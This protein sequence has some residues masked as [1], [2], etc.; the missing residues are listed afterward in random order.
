MTVDNR[1]GM[2]GRQICE[3]AT[4]Q[5][6]LRLRRCWLSPRCLTGGS[7]RALREQGRT[8]CLPQLDRARLLGGRLVAP[9]RRAQRR[10]EGAG[11]RRRGRAARPSQPRYRPPRGRA[12]T[13]AACSPRRASASARTPRHAIAAFRSSPASASLSWLSASA[14]AARPCAQERAAEQRRGL[15]RVDAEALRAQPLVGGAQAALGGGGVALEQLDEPGEDVGLEEPLRDAELLDHAPRRRDHAP[16]RLGAPAQRLEHRLAA[17]RDR[18]DRRRALRDAQHAHDVETA[19]ARARHRAR[20]PQRGQRRAGEH[21]VGAPPVAARA[22]RRRARGR[23][24]PRTRRS[25]R[26]ARARARAPSAPSPRRRRRPPRRAS[27]AAAAT[28]SAVARSACGSVSTASWPAKQVCQARRRSELAGEA[29]ELV[30]RPR[31]GADVAGREQRLAPVERQLGARGIRGI[32]PIERAAEQ[33]RRERQVVARR[34]R[35]GPRPRGSAPRA[36]RG[37][38]R[39]SSSG[40]S[41]RRCWCACSRCQ[42]IV[43]SCSTASPARASSQSAKRPCSSARVPFSSAPV[44]GVADQHVVEAQRPARRGTSRCRARSARC[45]AA[46]RAARRGRVRRPAAAG[47]RPRRART[48]GRRPRRARARCAPRGASR[49]MR[50]ASSAW[51]VGGISSAASSTPAVQRSPSRLSTPSWTSMRT[52][53]PTK[54]GLPSLVASTRPAIA[55]GSSSAPITFAASRVAAPASRPRERHHV[56]DETAGR[57]RATSARR[58]ARGAPPRGRAAARR[59]STA[60]GARSGRAAAAPPTAGRRSRARPAAAAASAARKAPDDEEGLLR[61]RRRPGEERGDARRRSGRARPRRRAPAPRSPRACASPSAPS[62]RRRCARSASASGAK[63]APPAASQRAVEHGRARRPSRRASSAS[64]RDLPRPGE[65][66]ITARR[67][68]GRATARVVDRRERAAARR[69]VRRSAVAGAPAGRS[70]ETTRYAATVSARPFRREGA[71]RRER[72]QLAHEAL[73]R[74]ADQRRRR[75]APPA[76]GAPRR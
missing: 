44:G 38:G 4:P 35:A 12:S 25:R 67:A 6:A 10:R 17:E 74:L 34:A 33:A 21:R 59:C 13:A 26:A 22:A 23:A 71:E 40:P 45:A 15:R 41:S 51:I 63:V 73:R 29:A 68:R 5:G 50:A 27:P 28:A 14:S 7:A 62:S 16:R 64:R 2:C 19:A 61:R 66:R 20:S 70:S 1:A 69:R 54:S 53:S 49:S 43:S 57:G 65:P 11:A 31:R 36:R 30:D 56:G 24:R 9:A 46:P 42:P 55:A 48:A 72:H 18:L 37:R 75:R 39:C 32:E 76:G 3:H 8:L 52:S 58:A 47:G 60:R